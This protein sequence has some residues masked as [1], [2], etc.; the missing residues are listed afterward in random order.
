M[1]C[2]HEHNDD[3]YMN[4]STPNFQKKKIDDIRQ[5]DLNGE[6]NSVGIEINSLGLPQS[7]NMFSHTTKLFTILSLNLA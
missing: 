2:T 7:L 4:I 3:N 6:E 5:H 1:I